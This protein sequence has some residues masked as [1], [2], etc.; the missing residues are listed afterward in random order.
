M[1]LQARLKSQGPKRILALDGG[2]MRGAITLG[3]LEEIQRQLRERHGDPGLELRDYFDLI[4]GTSTGALIAAGLASGLRVEDMIDLYRAMGPAVFGRKRRG[5]KKMRALFDVA[6]L[7]RELDDYFGSRTMDDPGI[8]TGLCI[9]AKR[10][11]TRSTWPLLNH[12]DGKYYAENRSIKLSAALRAS[13]AAPAV[14]QPVA[15]DVGG[16]ELGAFIDGGVSTAKNPALLLFL[17]ATLSGYP[18]HWETGEDDLLMVSIGTGFWSDHQPLE[19]VLNNRLWNWAMEVPGLFIEDVGWLNQLLLQAISDSPTPWTIDSEMG[20]LRRD[21]I[22]QQPLLSYLRYDV[23]LDAEGL[24]SVGVDH[25]DADLD[26]LRDMTR[27]E[28]VDELVRIGRTAA[29][30]QVEAA[31]FPAVFDVT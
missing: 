26:S 16:G 13:T 22:T 4:G 15:V 21:L 17:I 23:I 5:P 30:S 20:D 29:T 18:F 25:V 6:G 14:F 27:A 1:T 19:K 2:G 8:T 12:P 24:A 31:H 11:D 3:Y 9:V 7:E 10:A 28:N